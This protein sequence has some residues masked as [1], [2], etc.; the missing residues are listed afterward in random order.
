MRRA[1][2]QEVCG[3]RGCLYFSERP[4]VIFPFCHAEHV[5]G[6]LVMPQ[7]GRKESD[8]VSLKPAEAAEEAAQAH[9]VFAAVLVGYFGAAQ[10]G[11]KI[12][13]LSFAHGH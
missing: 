12:Q 9:R 10:Q 3:P 2:N 5:D 7:V 4:K 11:F 1:G 8:V 13:R 6:T